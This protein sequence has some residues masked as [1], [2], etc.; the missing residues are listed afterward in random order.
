M[1]R[2]S[3]VAEESIEEDVI[4]E[5]EP[6]EDEAIEDDA[7]EDDAMEDDAM[8][9][10]TDGAVDE[11]ELLLPQQPAKRTMHKPRIRT[12]ASDFLGKI[13]TSFRLC[14][15]APCA[16]AQRIIVNCQLSSSPPQVP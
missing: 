15:L 13:Q 4:I 5:D 9:D 2:G 10:E 7:I 8:E 14:S 11:D 6:I 12:S 16:R 1:V 3:G